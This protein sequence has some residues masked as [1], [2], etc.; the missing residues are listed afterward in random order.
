MRAFQVPCDSRGLDWAIKDKDTCVCMISDTRPS[1]FQHHSTADVWKK[2]VYFPWEN[3]P[4]DSHEL[5]QKRKH[6]PESCDNAFLLVNVVPFKF[7]FKYKV[8][9]KII[10][11]FYGSAKLLLPLV[12]HLYSNIASKRSLFFWFN[13]KF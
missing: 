7:H 10:S 2:I 1:C 9:F 6:L 8:T 3:Y 5:L 11:N 4:R 13:W 12:C